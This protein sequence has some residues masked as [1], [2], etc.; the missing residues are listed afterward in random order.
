[1]NLDLGDSFLSIVNQRPLLVAIAG[2]NGAGKSTFYHAHLRSSGL[3]FI[4]ADVIAT[5]L[6]MDAYVAAGVAD[7]IRRN[8]VDQRKSFIFETVFSDPAGEKLK[9]LLDAADRDYTVVL[10]FIGISAP[11]IS[12]T[13]VAMR[14][15]KGGHDV[16]TNKLF[17]RF[18]RT[19][20]NLRAALGILPHVYL[21][22][23]SNLS[24]PFRLVARFEEGNPID[25]R[26][27]LPGWLETILTKDGKLRG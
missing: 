8:L 1:V 27:P 22:D 10:F 7:N 2:P 9:F 26:Q 19:L 20:L 12:E 24:K 18:S 16:P 5:A 25:L 13:R 21:I 6:K 14:V 23:N 4:N 11:D 15:A 17:E 3:E